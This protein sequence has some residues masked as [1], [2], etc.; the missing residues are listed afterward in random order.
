MEYKIQKILPNLEGEIEI[1]HKKYSVPFV[2]PG[3]IVKFQLKKF[4]RKKK[5]IPQSIIK[6]H[7]P[8]FEFLKEPECPYFG[9]CGGCKGQHLQYDFQWKLK[10]K[11]LKHLYE[12]EFKISI[13]EVQAN[14]IYH[15]RNRMDFVVTENII[16]MRKPQQFNQF[17]DIEYCYIQN[18]KANIILKTFREVFKKYSNLGFNRTTKK[19]IIKY[20]TIRTGI[21]IYIIFT[22]YENSFQSDNTKKLYEEFIKEFIQHIKEIEDKYKFSI[23]VKE[24]FIDDKAEISNVSNGK[25]LYG[26]PLL[27]INFDDLTI[28]IPPDAFFQPNPEIISK[29]MEQCIEDLKEY[30]L[31]EKEKTFQLID[32]FCGV[33]IL[34]IYLTNKIKDHIDSVLGIEIHQNAVELAKN[35]FSRFFGTNIETN[36]FTSDLTKIIS[37]P[38]NKSSIL[39][40]DPP[41]TGIQTRLINW[42]I[43]SPNL[44]WIL[45][46]SC[47]PEKQY[48][49]IQKLKHHFSIKTIIFGD[50][51]P[52]TS[53]WES[54]ILLQKNSSA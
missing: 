53:H 49:D 34:S 52:Q 54:L 51:F 8:N 2:L 5:L 38:M 31:I 32:L 23:S 15:Y 44:E 16:G 46:L 39:I 13:K 17:I 37:I 48:Q 29:M 4:G 12:N 26:N 20:I 14:Q 7:N 50:P 10:I 19:G 43:N 40:L 41:R 1:H 6:E 21:N 42:L 3:D 22:N 11:E 27:T 24:C 35:N 33:G 36:F 25:V 28:E 30:L 45:Y 47:N 18:E 9:E